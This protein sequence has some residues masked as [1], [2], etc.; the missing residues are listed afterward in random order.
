MNQHEGRLS[1][2]ARTHEIAALTDEEA[3]E[4][5]RVYGETFGPSSET[6]S[7]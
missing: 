4:I 6:H 3:N 2:R 5:E 1:G 7:M